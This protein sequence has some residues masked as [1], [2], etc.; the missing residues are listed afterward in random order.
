M[1]QSL[2]REDIIASEMTD[3]QTQD[4][5]CLNVALRESTKALAMCTHQR[6]AA[7]H[8]HAKKF[9]GHLPPCPNDSCS[10][11]YEIVGQWCPAC[12]EWRREII[13]FCRKGY[14]DRIVWSR[15][16]SSEWLTNPY[17]VARV[18]I[19]R[20]HK[21]YYKSNEF[22]EDIRYSLS[23]IENSIS[24]DVPKDLVQKVWVVRN[25]FRRKGKMKIT[26]KDLNKCV[27]CLI[28]LLEVPTIYTNK[29]VPPAVKKLRS[30]NKVEE[31]SCVIL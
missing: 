21:F 22:H 7:F 13:Q 8:R 25:S 19:P 26:S 30:I 1:G 10:K 5:L 18:L 3:P 31:S 23:Y 2:N 24:F 12:A 15:Y 16:S 6:I 14:I 9:I 28:D 20:A 29:A 17:E 11:N 4:W 27:S